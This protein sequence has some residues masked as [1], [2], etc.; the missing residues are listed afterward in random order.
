[1]ATATLPR[2]ET[3]R[4]TA[5]AAQVNANPVSR[6]EFL[7]YIWGASLVLLMGEGVA[8]LIWFAIPR[9]KEGTFGGIVHIAPNKIPK[10]DTAPYHDT[11][12]KFWVSN[13]DEGLVML[14]QVCTHLGCIPKWIETNNR[15]ECPCHGS[16]YQLD[17]H[18][19]E[20]P[21]PRSLDRFQTTITFADGSTAA[22][23]SAGDPIP[24]AGKTIAD[25]VVDTGKRIKRDGRV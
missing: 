10:A 18:Y 4:K 21:A 13:S 25:V 3:A 23:D 22:S 14:Y 15:F 11:D 24:I 19:I 17:G 20:G 2:R 6:R 12:A 16:K 5:A 9:F 7:Y 8:G 1:M